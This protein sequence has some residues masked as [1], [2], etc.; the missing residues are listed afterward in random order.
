MIPRTPPGPIPAGPML[1]LQ[2]RKPTIILEELAHS[3]QMLSFNYWDSLLSFYLSPFST[4][5]S[6]L[7]LPRGRD[8]S[9]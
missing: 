6:K 7:S 9:S 8:V 5:G 4:L 2:A 1:L 3:S